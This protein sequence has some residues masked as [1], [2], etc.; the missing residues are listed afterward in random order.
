MRLVSLHLLH[1]VI[2]ID[3]DE[4]KIKLKGKRQKQKSNKA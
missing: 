4:W 2:G 3:P 1:V